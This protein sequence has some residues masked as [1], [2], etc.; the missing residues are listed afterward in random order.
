M[1]ALRIDTGG[2]RPTRDDWLDLA[3]ALLARRGVGAVTALDLSQRLGVSRSSFYW[4]FRSRDGLLDTLLQRWEDLNTRSIVRETE[5]PAETIVEAVLNVFRCWVDAALFSPRLDLAVREWARCSELVRLRL[6]RSDSARMRAIEAMF[7]RH[8]YPPD[9]ALVRA[10][11][12]YT[13]QVGYYALDISEPMEAR[14]A[15]AP[16]YLRIFTDVDPSEGELAA[17]R[18]YALSH[19]GVKDFDVQP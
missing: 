13:M 8:G 9:D 5:A 2:A 12:L 18:A 14:L 10:R 7:R 1:T 16:H 15:L 6:D 11:V 17:F 3:L 4:H 19:G